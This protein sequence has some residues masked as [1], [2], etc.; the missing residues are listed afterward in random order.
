MLDAVKRA[1]GGTTIHAGP[2]KANENLI[3]KQREVGHDFAM[4]VGTGLISGGTAARMPL[5]IGR[6]ENLAAV[7][8]ETGETWTR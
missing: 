7:S 5:A 4:S 2:T 8:K 6:A 3:Q 1:E